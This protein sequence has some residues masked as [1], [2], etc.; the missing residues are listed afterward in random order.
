MK[1]CNIDKLMIHIIILIATIFVSTES[2]ALEKQSD[3]FNGLINFGDPNVKTFKK[4]FHKLDKPNAHVVTITQFG[5]SHSAA[6]FFTGELRTLLQAKYGNAGIGWVTPMYV[7]GQY[8]S[9]VTWKSSNWQLFSSRNT[10]DRDFPMGG[11]IAE[12]NKNNS[13][14]QVTP[15]N[16]DANNDEWLVRLTIKPLKK[17]TKVKLVDV[18]HNVHPIIFTKKNK[19]GQWQVLPVKIK[20]PFTIIT[21]KGEAELGGIWLQRYQKSGVIVSMIGTNG[22]K[23]SI[24]QKWSPNWYNQLAITKSNMVIL[25]YGTNETFDSTLD[26]DEYRKNLIGNIKKIRETLPHAVVLLMSSPDTMLKTVQSDNIFDRRPTNYYQ[27]RQI[28]QE[29][30]KQQ[31]TL[32]WDWQTAMGGEGIIEKW[33]FLDLARPDLVHLTKQGYIESA[34]IFYRDLVTFIR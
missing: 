24:W 34:K 10:N 23:Q 20:A 9:G 2:I 8:H 30:A 32:Y 1:V 7:A 12:A 11:Y 16:I 26:L 33:L 27:I 3:S 29:V 18:A 31:K 14:I 28:Q 22:A 6:D 17:L 25:E 4:D 13:Y 15:K 19:I 21:N 5:D